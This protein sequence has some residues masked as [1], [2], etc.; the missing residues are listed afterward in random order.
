MKGVDQDRFIDLVNA[1]KQSPTRGAS[2]FW[3]HYKTRIYWGN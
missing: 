1:F 3:A 2:S